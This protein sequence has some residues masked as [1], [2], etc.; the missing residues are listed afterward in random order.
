MGRFFTLLR[1]DLKNK[2]STLVALVGLLVSL[3]IW[4]YLLYQILVRVQAS[5]LMFFLFW[6]YVP[7]SLL[8]TV[9][10]KL[11]ESDDLLAEIGK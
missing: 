10:S 11:L 7:V 6:V 4:F 5:E 9:I 1:S 8:I 3:P 2:L